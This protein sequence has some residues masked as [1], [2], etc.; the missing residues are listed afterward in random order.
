V[1]ARNLTGSDSTDVSR[2]AAEA[3]KA[4]EH[5]N[6]RNIAALRGDLEPA[7]REALALRQ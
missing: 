5:E 3:A 1:K 6:L 4:L 2:E 7:W